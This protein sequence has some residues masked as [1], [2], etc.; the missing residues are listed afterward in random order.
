M[1]YLFSTIHGSHLYGTDHDASDFDYFTVVEKQP[2]RGGSRPRWS[3]QTLTSDERG[4]VQDHTVVDL[5][6][7]LLGCEKGAPQYLEAMFSSN[8]IIDKISEF[9]S[10]F[11]VGT[12]VID[13]YLRTIKSFSLSDRYD[14]EK[15]RRHA[16]RLAVNARSILEC[17]RFDPRLS[18]EQV[19]EFTELA[20]KDPHEVYEMALNIVWN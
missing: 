4:A 13:T 1:T 19:V 6:T 8:P 11:R 12:S 16:L 9:R 14:A 3:R 20:K 15:K 7:F 10:G 2:Y 17:G 18:P 5:S